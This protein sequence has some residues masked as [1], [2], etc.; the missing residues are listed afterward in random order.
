MCNKQ[1]KVRVL[2]PTKGQIH[3]IM[4]IYLTQ[5]RWEINQL[6][7][8]RSA[9]TINASHVIRNSQYSERVINAVF[10]ENSSVVYTLADPSSNLTM[11]S[12]MLEFVTI[13]R[14][15]NRGLIRKL[16]RKIELS[17]LIL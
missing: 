12:K 6:Y 8:K 7:H 15:N 2:L 17:M 1:P 3:L 4:I 14:N 5:H 11:K 10:V 16:N 13:A 9:P